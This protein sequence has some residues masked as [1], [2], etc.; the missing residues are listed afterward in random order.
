MKILICSKLFYPSNRIGAV[1]PSNFARYLTRFGYEVVVITDKKEIEKEFI[2]S[3][4]DIVRISNSN[5]INKI[6]TKINKRV[7]LKKNKK[8]KVEHTIKAPKSKFYNKAKKIKIKIRYYFHEL[9]SLVIDLNW[10]FNTRKYIDQ[11]YK[12]SS[13]DLVLS[14][15]GPLSSF[16]LGK[17]VKKEKI[18]TYWISD[19]RDNMRFEGYSF[20]LNEFMKL[21]EKRALNKADAIT[22]ISNDQRAMFMD[23]LNVKDIQKQKIHTIYNGYENKL[24]INNRNKTNNNILKLVYTGQ[25]YKS[26]RDFCMLFQAVD[27]LIEEGKIDKRIIEIK[28]AGPDS[29]ELSQQINKFKNIKDICTDLGFID[30]NKA[31]KLQKESDI[32]VVLTWNTNKSKG[33]LTGKFLEYLQ[34]QKPIISLTTGDLPNGELTRLVRGL[35][36]GIACEYNNYKLDY[37][38]LKQYILEQYNLLINHNQLNF[39]P[40]NELIKKFHYENISKELSILIDSISKSV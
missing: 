31:I 19:F 32:L 23:N 17:F 9:F 7:V 8:L 1:R 34:S 2:L 4:V 28:Y 39:T 24:E 3:N 13:F 36:L 21:C 29:N 30:R 26:V 14:S 35:N 20:W 18:A 10:Y 12:P 5:S 22:F 37:L 16:L 33:N 15:Y 6:I 40:N 25:L 27:D 11:H 38:K